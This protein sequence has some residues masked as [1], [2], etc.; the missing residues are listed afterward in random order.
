MFYYSQALPDLS[1]I[2]AMSLIL[3]FIPLEGEVHDFFQPVT[4]EILRLFKGKECLPTDPTTSHKTSP[5]NTMRYIVNIFRQTSTKDDTDIQW[6]QPSQLLSVH[7]D[8]IREYIPQ[9]LLT[10]A[11]NLYYLN[12]ILSSTLSRDLCSQLNIGVISIDHL[13]AV[14][15]YALKEY[16]SERGRTLQ[17][18]FLEESLM[19]DDDEE[20]DENDLSKY[21]VKWIAHWLACV[22]S[23]MED[24]RDFTTNTLS[25][26]K[27]LPIIPLS[28]GDMVSI[29]SGPIFF[30]PD[31]DTGMA[32]ILLY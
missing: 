28:N 31:S 7:L 17:D 4:G 9:S 27:R 5:T 18:L 2:E 22:H 6:K 14:A 10:S 23:L 32:I 30:P 15:E 16:Q 19:E 13:L 26:L 20:L 25:K 12:G 3:Q 29:E 8:I 21:F 1:E 11:L 24:T